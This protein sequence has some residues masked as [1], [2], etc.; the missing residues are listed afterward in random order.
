MKYTSKAN[1]FQTFSSGSDYRSESKC[2]QIGSY[3]FMGIFDDQIINTL[4]I[5]MKVHTFDS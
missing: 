3:V 1:V 5:K 2:L 4:I